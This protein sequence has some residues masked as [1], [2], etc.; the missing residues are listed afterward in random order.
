M[1]GW[2]K[3]SYH[4]YEDTPHGMV[5]LCATVYTASNI[6]CPISFPFD[7]RMTASGPDEGSY[8]GQIKLSH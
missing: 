5:E 6:E 8:N 4:V 1:V 2:E 7:V 3:V